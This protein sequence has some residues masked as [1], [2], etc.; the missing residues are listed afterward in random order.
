MMVR[1][2]VFWGKAELARTDC[3]SIYICDYIKRFLTRKED[4]GGGTEESLRKE[5]VISLM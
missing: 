1:L 4:G 5:K 2:V 3:W